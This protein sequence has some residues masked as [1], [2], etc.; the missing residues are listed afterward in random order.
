VSAQPRKARRY[1]EELVAVAERADNSQLIFTARTRLAQNLTFL[2]EFARARSLLE[3]AKNWVEEGSQ[4]FGGD[5]IGVFGLLARVLWFLGFPTQAA[6]RNEES[7][8][9]SRAAAAFFGYNLVMPASVTILLRD[10][11]RTMQLANELDPLARDYASPFFQDY[12]QSCGV[13]H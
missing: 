1:A 6:R 12:T 8:V 7:L 13:P 5:K 4:W 11:S 9:L 3:E 10:P 2:S